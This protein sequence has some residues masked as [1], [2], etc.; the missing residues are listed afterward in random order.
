[1]P[2]STDYISPEQ[3]QTLYGLFVQRIAKSPENTAYTFFD[4]VKEQWTDLSWRDMSTQIG[5]W[6]AA[7]MGE[8]LGEGERVAIMLPNSPEWVC[9]DIAALSLGLVV[10]PLFAND[11][12]DN[13][14]YILEQTDTKV[15]LCPGLAYWNDLQP[16]L[17]RLK[18]I[19]RI[20]T[21]DHCK[22]QEEDPRIICSSDWLGDTGSTFSSP[23]RDPDTL[24]SIVYTSGTAGPPK[25]V[26]L[27]HR[28]IV[29]NCY[30]GLQAIAIYPS[31]RFLSFLPMSHMLERTVG[32]YLPIMAGASVA[33]VRSIPHLKEDIAF[34]RPTALI[35]VP[36]IFEKIYT[37]ILSQLKNKS[38]AAR[39]LFKL[40]VVSGWHFF[41][42]SQ[43]RASWS[44]LL[45]VHPLLDRIIGNKVR[46]KLGGRLRVIIS[47]GA[48]LAPDI[49]KLFLG[50]GL[51]LYQGYGLTET[52]PVI[53][54]NREDDNM[55]AGVGPPLSGIQ[56]RIGKQDELEVWGSCVML[57]YWKDVAATN[58]VMTDD[59]WLRTGDKVRIDHGHIV[60][61]G[62]LKDIIVLNNSEKV[63]P[64]DLE[65]AIALDPLIDQV[66][67]IG[68]NRPYLT[69]VAVLNPERW[70][71]LCEKLHLP[72]DTLSLTA[73]SV[74]QEILKRTD[75]Q[76][77]SFPGF[78]WIKQASLTLEPWTVEN[79]L[80]TPTLKIKREKIQEKLKQE[81]EAMYA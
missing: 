59:G 16:V 41:E 31:D 11:R 63:A 58:N 18:N 21:L 15:L 56:V 3:A 80:L 52:S 48:A 14:A 38:I 71:Q 79:G 13:I 32:Y 4:K 33:F 62:R 24:A 17:Y 36:R 7:L 66:M 46:N 25:G 57:G 1:M 28:N 10:V 40:A 69:M 78:A 81:I 20:I 27:S 51:P 74:Q 53:S 9:Y 35:A 6:Q 77:F 44:P 37:G 42:Y 26:M 76:L 54:V 55:P 60:I 49:A 50:L 22:T 30:A 29:E 68:E 8:G 43:K 34:I 23:E 67:V 12:P 65:M 73:E 61:T 75:K 5:I 47:G 2:E 19:Q 64:V 72:K 70:E 45:L 39:L